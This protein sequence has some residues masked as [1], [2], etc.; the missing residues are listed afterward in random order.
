MAGPSCLAQLWQWTVG[1][2]SQHLTYL[3][4]SY[5]TQYDLREES[6]LESRRNT[7]REYRASSE[8]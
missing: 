2:P 7:V 5:Q 3:V 4:N 8:G 6:V 1:P